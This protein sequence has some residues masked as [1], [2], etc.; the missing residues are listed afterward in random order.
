MEQCDTKKEPKALSL[1]P[2]GCPQS[3]TC[4]QHKRLGWV[5]QDGVRFSPDP[6]H[7]LLPPGCPSSTRQPSSIWPG[8][9]EYW[10]VFPAASALMF[11]PQLMAAEK[12][13]AAHRVVGDTRS[14]VGT[15]NCCQVFFVILWYGCTQTIRFDFQVLCCVG[16]KNASLSIKN[17]FLLLEAIM[18]FCINTIRTDTVHDWHNT[19]RYT[20]HL[21]LL[22]SCV[23][24]RIS[25]VCCNHF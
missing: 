13:C 4:S 19:G 24:S 6:A 3:L 9:L 8:L 5:V 14:K 17:G 1:T 11:P 10:G 2:R 23:S 15:G 16:E 25:C 12:C 18:A 21:T 22:S 20:C 7:L